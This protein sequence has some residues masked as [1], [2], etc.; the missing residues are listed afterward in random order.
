MTA[1]SRN[2]MAP[3]TLASLALAAW[4]ASAAL[5]QARVAA[6]DNGMYCTG[7]AVT[8][9]QACRFEVA[10]DFMKASAICINSAERDEREECSEEA[11]AA[12]SEGLRACGQQLAARRSVCAE[13]GEGRYDP[14]FDEIDFETDFVN[15]TR[16]N[17]WFPLRIGNQWELRG[18]GEVVKLEVLNATKLIDDVRCI[19]L[20]DI[21]TKD[22]KLV[23]DTDDWFAVARDGNVW[24]C[25]E[26]VKDYETFEGD[27]PP[28]PQLVSRD[29]SFKAGSDG[30]KAGIIFQGNPR[31]G[32]VY[33]EEFSIGNAEDLSR[34]LSTNYAYGRNPNLDR[35]VPATL[36]Q[37]LCTGDCVVL[38]AYTAR[39]PGAFAYK[40][41]APG[42]GVFL[43]IT[44][45]TGKVVQLV[46]CNVD[47]RCASLPRL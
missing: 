37:L 12:R 21:V 36:A 41:Y 1:T 46:S 28:R 4:S 8:V 44:P 27:A 39:E 40:Y 47:P 38:K 34:V 7:T 17:R 13:V 16:K 10:D 45:A 43:D 9:E 3:F 5:P 19:V 25:G 42:I 29:G 2:S 26:E 15:P 32:Q 14:E 24:Y 6:A 31:V 22:G 30:D 18:A 23:E 20:R 11:V 33:R 35:L